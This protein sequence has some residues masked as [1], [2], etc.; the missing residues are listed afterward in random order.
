M[1]ELI[2]FVEWMKNVN[3]GNP[4][5]SHQGPAGNGSSSSTYPS[6]PT[7]QINSPGQTKSSLS[8]PCLFSDV[9]RVISRIEAAFEDITTT[10]AD[11]RDLGFAFVNEF[12]ETGRKFYHRVS[13][14]YPGYTKAETDRQYDN[15]LKSH[16][17]GIT[18]KTFFYLAQQA[19]I[20]VGNVQCSEG[21]E[22][23]NRENEEERG[24]DTIY[25]VRTGTPSSSCP[26]A[27]SV[28]PDLPTLPDALF[29]RLP[30]FFKQVVVMADSKEERDMLF[31]GSLVTISS[32]LGKFSGYY[33]RRKV[34]PNLYLYVTAPASA[35]KGNLVM[36][37]HLV[38]LIDEERSNQCY[39]EGL[40]YDQ[41][42]REYNA[43]KNKDMD[44]DKPVPP[45]VRMLFIPAN[46]ST[47]GFYQLL[48]D[49]DGSGLLF[50]TEG[51]TLTQAFKT[52]YGNFS[53]GVR[54]AFHHEPISYFRRTGR[55]N[56]R[57]RFPRLSVVIS[58]TIGQLPG[59]VPNVEN[60]LASRFMFYHMNLKPVWHDV[61]AR[62]SEHSWDDH[63]N[64]LGHEFYSMYTS[65][66]AV[67]DI[68][69]Q[70]SP[71]QSAQFN[72][73]FTQLQERYLTLKGMEILAIVRRLGLITF[74]I[75]MILT[76]MRIPE[77]GDFSTHQEC[78]E[79]DFKSALSI[80]S[81]LVRHA[82]YVMSQLPAEVKTVRGQSSKERFFESLAE[83]FNRQD[84]IALGKSMQVSE[85]TAQNYISAFCDKGLIL[86]EQ[87]DTYVKG[88]P[89]NGKKQ[90]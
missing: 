43:M 69:F 82:S 47:T 1:N 71:E 51:D 21:S 90:Q 30:E 60:G 53:D 41:Q 73:F 36:C 5:I 32:C 57:I 31:L 61:L 50:E 55:E 35:G 80:I 81:V 15:C 44:I 56:V 14:F 65:L 18:I 20:K 87:R 16:G 6:F 70:L 40:L 13:R 29:E 10:Y 52:D 38:D 2:N 76:A 85:R 67:D 8:N 63:F 22:V 39:M 88:N 74:R 62:D 3:A 11:W 23:E 77:T 59:L 27:S 17:H 46:N 37:R 24:M 75:M 34:Y 66:K 26:L 4:G 72:A 48:A 9:D 89:L 45:P 83:R 54:K 25:R 78:L 33:G 64:R 19:G 28:P 49:N 7:R 84:Y 58:S 79:E 42:M 68:D 86:R 12:G